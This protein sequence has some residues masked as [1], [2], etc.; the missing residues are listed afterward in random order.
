MRFN[1]VRFHMA[2]VLPLVLPLFAA[3]I[4]PLDES[5]DDIDTNEESIGVATQAVMTKWPMPNPATAGLPHPAYYTTNNGVVTDHVTS[6]QWEA[7]AGCAAGC[8]QADAAARCDNLTLRG[9]DDWRLPTRIELV[10]IVD[11]MR[12]APAIDTSMFLGTLNGYY[13]SSTPVIGFND[14]FTVGGAEG[15]T[16][17]RNV[18][19]LDIVRCV[20]GLSPAPASAFVIQADDTVV[21]GGTGL[22]WERKASE[23]TYTWSDAKNYCEAKPGW[24]LP[25]MK[26]LQTIVDD[27]QKAPAI[28]SVAFP[29]TPIDVPYWTSTAV[30]WQSGYA[31]YVLFNV[32]QS[33]HTAVNASYRVRC[34]SDSG[35]AFPASV[36]IRLHC[37][38]GSPI[39]ETIAA[40]GCVNL[41]P[42]NRIRTSFA[43][44]NGPGSVT[45]YEGL[46]CTGG[47]RQISAS[48]ALCGK[49]FDNG[50]QMN[51]RVQSISFP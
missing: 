9:Y 10:S 24:R 15:D 29:N 36:S 43:T 31:W 39:L 18:S 14:T 42:D 21:D 20:R 41:A 49:T 26:E 38:S 17:N 33:N 50:G 32:G 23:S 25:S 45:F 2:Y 46:D 27:S 19:T 22:T 30:S 47:K 12:H 40:A 5:A 48:M 51:D 16:S 1:G 8:T 11:Y 37:Q 6:L 4:G 7:T 3:C 35:S 44:L 13:K 34:V 28:D